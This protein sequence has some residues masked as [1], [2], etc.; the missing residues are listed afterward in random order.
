MYKKLLVLILIL[1]IASTASSAPNWK[2]T[3]A[4]DDQWD[5]P[6]N[7]LDELGAVATRVPVYDQE[8][9]DFL[10]GTN[11]TVASGV[12]AESR[13]LKPCPIG[14]GTSTITVQDGGYLHTAATWYGQIGGTHSTLT[15]D[16]GGELE[17]DGRWTEGIDIGN[18]GSGACTAVLN[19][20]GLFWSP[21]TGYDNLSV[22]HGGATGEVY[23][24]DT[25]VMLAGSLYLGDD[26]SLDIA[27]AGRLELWGNHMDEFLP[28]GTLYEYIN[29][30]KMTKDG[31]PA[32][33]SDFI[34]WSE[35]DRTV[36][37]V[38]EPMTISLL[39]LGGLALI[40]RKR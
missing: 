26:G 22:G 31:A 23:I 20:N 32:E 21:L 17:V 29:L 7:W 8:N 16:V 38:P 27:G 28:G 36:I 37:L 13:G 18:G 1:S 15:V 34:R 33:V 3:G 19:V 5:K 24:G 25:G 30:S 4:I 35:A 2:F 9:T 14:G 10:D 11:A 12:T 39:G 6:G 40:R